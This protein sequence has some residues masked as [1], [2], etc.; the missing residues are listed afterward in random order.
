MSKSQTTELARLAEVADLG[1]YRQRR[2]ELAAWIAA[3][4][5]LHARGL[6]AAVPAW[7][8]RRGV[9]ADWYYAA[10]GTGAP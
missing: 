9:L 5:H 2:R 6:P 4:E 1:A 3:I 10:T 8:G 7:L